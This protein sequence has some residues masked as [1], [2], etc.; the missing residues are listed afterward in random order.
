MGQMR[1][2]FGQYNLWRGP[3]GFDAEKHSGRAQF[4]SRRQ[5]NVRVQIIIGGWFGG[6]L[7]RR[8]DLI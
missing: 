1:G 6:P 7:K 5:F 2:A 3:K 8:H 4:A